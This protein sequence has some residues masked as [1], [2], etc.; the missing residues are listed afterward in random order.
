MSNP[1]EE[2]DKRVF[3]FTASGRQAQKHYSNTIEDSLSWDT[4]Q[5]Y[6]PEKVNDL[7]NRLDG[8][9]IYAWGLTPG[10]RNTPL[11]EEKMRAGHFVLSYQKKNLTGVFRI[12]GRVHDKEL[13]M[14]L[15]GQS[16]QSDHAGEAFEYIYFL[17]K[18][19]TFNVESPK[20]FRGHTEVHDKDS[21]WE[22][23]PEETQNKITGKKKIDLGDDNIQNSK[24]D[25]IEK[26]LED[27]KQV[28][29]YGPPGTGKTY[30]AKKYARK[31]FGGSEKEFREPNFKINHSFF[32]DLKKIDEINE[33]FGKPGTGKGYEDEDR[34]K[35]AEKKIKTIKE[36]WRNLL[37]YLQE[38]VNGIE[39][40]ETY[41][42]PYNQ[43]NNQEKAWFWL[44]IHEGDEK[45]SEEEQLQVYIN[46]QGIRISLWY[47]PKKENMKSL[48]R[49]LAKASKDDIKF[50]DE[51]RVRTED[52]DNI[53]KGE[54]DLER[55]REI[56]NEKNTVRVDFS[57]VIKPE[58]IKGNE[59]SVIREI[60]EEVETGILPLFKFAVDETEKIERPSKK[61]YKQVTFHPS[62][63]YE[64]FIEGIKA[65]TEEEGQVNYR[66]K[67]GIFKK[68]C[69]KARKSNEDYLLIIDEINRGNIPSIF[70][71]LITLLEDDKRG[72]KT[73]LPYSNDDFSIPDNLCIIGTMNT[74]D[75]SI[76]LMDVALRRRFCHMEFN[77]D[78]G[79][80]VNKGEYESLQ[81]IQNEAS[82]GDMKALSVL[83]LRNINEEL[84]ERNLES[85]KK[86]G[87]SYFMDVES[88]EEVLHVWKYELIPLLKEY[89][90][91]NFESI[92]DILVDGLVDSEKKTIRDFSGE[93]LQ[94]ALKELTGIGGESE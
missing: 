75:R 50:L 87:H 86:I 73:T 79:E 71:E 88:D 94:N 84:M 23:L 17:D 13:A 19:D 27:K 24:F 44:S 1:F 16:K 12:V 80:Y 31:Y 66:V 62:F 38:N 78:I 82:R 59:T 39:K 30:W 48:N 69:N 57:K 85:G 40:Y 5:E 92:S 81:E 22:A 8:S 6:I 18:I 83:A 10:Q 89:F 2:E 46:K 54:P 56:V 67:D 52:G 7:R 35:E 15:W 33:E 43:G 93:D 34:G 36:T 60:A 4:L 29:F 41:I 32:Q 77:P 20:Q 26:L 45:Y 14:E 61:R 76:A 9:D 64:E 65:E 70:G 55:V 72:D 63:S 37:E 53:Y 21:F 11:W 47:E 68:W 91:D 58:E 28:I 3:V 90:F 51:V 49:F 42:P 74:A 25:S